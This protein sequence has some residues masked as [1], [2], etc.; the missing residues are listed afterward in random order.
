MEQKPKPGSK[1]RASQGQMFVVL[2]VV[3]VKDQTWV[4]YREKDKSQEYSCFLESFYSRFTEAT[5]E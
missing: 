4:H 2:E 3:D 1:W 5:N